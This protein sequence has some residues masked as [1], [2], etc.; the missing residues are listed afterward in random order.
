MAR[1]DVILNFIS[2]GARTV[3]R[4]LGDIRTQSVRASRAV[5]NLDR[6]F[7]ALAGFLT[8]RALQ[9]YADTFT[10]LQNR[11]R[12]VTEGT[13][14][15]NIVTEELFG[16]SQRTFTRL[17][18]TG[19]LYA[20]LA[21][22]VSELN[23]TQRELLDITES[24][25]QATA[26]SSPTIQAAQ[27]GLVQLAQAIGSDRL[28]G[29]ELRSILEN[30][31]R[32]GQAIA[33]GLGVPFQKLRELGAEGKLTAQEVL[34]ALESQIDVVQAEFAK[35]VPSI[36]FALT[37]LDNAF[38]KF[39]G[40]TDQ[41]AGASRAI[42]KSIT[43]LADN[44]NTLATAVLTA[45][46]VL[47]GG[48][49]AGA[50]G[51]ITVAVR[52]LAAGVGALSA[53]LAANPIGATVAV[54][55]L[56]IAALV[57]F[58]NQIRPLENDLVTLGDIFK[59]TGSII[60]EEFTAVWTQFEPVFNQF[61]ARV[62][63]LWNEVVDTTSFGLGILVDLSREQA[64]NF[65]GFWVGSFRA[66]GL[67]FE[68]GFDALIDTARTDLV[69][70]GNVVIDGLEDVVNSA[71]DI[72]DLDSLRVNI[73]RL[74]V[75]SEA[76]ANA[77][78][79][80]SD[81]NAILEDAFN[82]DFIGELASSTSGALDDIITRIKNR[83]AEI[84]LA[85]EATRLQGEDALNRQLGTGGDDEGDP[86]G[87]LNK[88][89][90]RGKETSAIIANLQREVSG[91]NELLKMG[92]T[93]ANN[94]AAAQAIINRQ[95]LDGRTVTDAQAT[96]IARLVAT[97]NDL[98]DLLSEQQR[99]LETVN[100]SQERYALGVRAADN[101]LAQSLI[102]LT[103]YR[104]IMRDVNLELLDAGR[105]AEDGFSRGIIRLEDDLTNFAKSAEDLL[106]GT[107]G[108]V[109][110]AFVSF[111]QTGK[112]SFSDLA[113]SILADL[114]RI[115][116]RESIAGIFGGGGTGGGG[117]FD[118]IFQGI[119]GFFGG[120]TGFARGGSFD[121]DSANSLGNVGGTDN[122]L[123]A[124]RARDGEN[125]TVTPPG[126]NAGGETVNNFNFNINTPDADSFGRSQS[127]LMA[128]ATA[129]ANRA[130]ARNN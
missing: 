94:Y 42:S 122:R 3:V 74:E 120:L 55:G 35:F 31:P 45:G 49:I 98:T 104:D 79:F 27:A 108:K 107:F 6:A 89:R 22:S 37:Q 95:L 103:E 96:E 112:L 127:Q 57:G 100:G 91:L 88:V 69:N 115:A 13:A 50:I 34:G 1:E 86:D 111:T 53:V 56:A 73:P 117:V 121:V 18:D 52:G 70:L 128:R 4:N 67:I 90:Q 64:N 116:F 8:I 21:R 51:Q 14:E 105:N 28:Q 102:T 76:A 7:N 10:L 43:F 119:G 71:A 40:Q 19:T 101:L 20:R 9:Q 5:G 15:L 16:I 38:L 24:I 130:A 124:F 11:L 58:Q 75:D 87:A 23:I 60:S 77:E 84:A 41:A 113:N 29:D 129:M 62:E 81:F 110:D 47:A 92:T 118:S 33:D 78:A 59:A 61:T 17:E 30:I 97:Q 12:L 114:T 2:R 65:I 106:T 82:T 123:I 46:A 54:I 66:L 125:V 63:A 32:V 85:R 48:A 109:E 126:Q 36:S 72:L 93:D 99:L 26:L 83:A 80:A 44:F 39:I 68:R 25:N